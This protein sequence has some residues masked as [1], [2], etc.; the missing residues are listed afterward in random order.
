[1]ADKLVGEALPSPTERPR[2]IPPVWL[3]A[4]LQLPFGIGGFFSSATL[5]RILKL[6]HVEPTKIDTAIGVSVL[7]AGVQFL[8]A[9]TVDIKFRRKTWYILLAFLAAG[10]LFGAMCVPMPTHVNLFITL[11]L[12]AQLAICLTSACVGG[13]MVTTVPDHLRGRASGFS[14]FGNIGAGAIGGGFTLQLLEHHALP[15]VGLAVAALMAIPSLIVLVVDEP[16][17]PKRSA[18]EIFG[19]MLREVWATVKQRSGWTGIL[20]CISPVSTAAAMQLFT[21]FSDNYNASARAT[22]LINGYLG[23][24]LTGSACLLGGW[25]C[26][27][28]S[29]RV[30][31][32]ISGAVTAACALGMA[33]APATPTAYAIGALTYLFITGFCY[34]AFT[35]FILE[36]VGEGGATASTRYTLFSSAGNFAI[37]YAIKFDGWGRELYQHTW[38]QAAIF[39]PH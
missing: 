2:R 13:L 3:F 30:A 32:L 29:R 9:P 31:Y 27:R 23:G 14:N 18:R 20:L 36:V 22:T 24:A 12:V 35:S 26:D 28:M 1:L 19:T 39:R 10:L 16:P 38:S 5:G 17:V 33:L 21:T 7:I 6:N 8:W 11:V 34:A 4:L 37:F 25:I 15:T